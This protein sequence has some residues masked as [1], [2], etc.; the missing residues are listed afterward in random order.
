[1]RA[2]QSFFTV[3]ICITTA[4]EETKNPITYQHWQE[5]L[6]RLPSAAS[7]HFTFV[8]YQCE[9]RHCRAG[10]E[11]CCVIIGNHQH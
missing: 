5:S 10:N 4:Y 8:L 11:Q 3:N 1:M 6:R 2:S 9:A 7:P